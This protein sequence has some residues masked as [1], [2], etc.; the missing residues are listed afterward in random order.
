MA[1]NSLALYALYLRNEETQDFAEL[2]RLEGGIDLYTLL[3]DFCRQQKTLGRQTDPALR[4]SVKL[5]DFTSDPN[6]RTIHGWFEKGD[7]GTRGS[8]YNIDTDARTYTKGPDETLPE[9]FYFSITLP[10]GETRAFLAFQRIGNRS[11]QSAFVGELKKSLRVLNGLYELTV[12]NVLTQSFIRELL[13]AG[14]ISEIRMIGRQIPS[15]VTRLYA[16]GYRD[17]GGTVELAI[18]ADRG[19]RL[20]LNEQIMQAFRRRGMNVSEIFVFEDMNFEYEELKV[21][22]TGAGKDWTIDLSDFN[23]IRPYYLMNENIQRDD[24]GHPSIEAVHAFA[25]DLVNEY[26]QEAAAEIEAE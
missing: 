22:V 3:E 17:I 4:R 25:M 16:Y 26:R 15:D 9:P 18:K 11:I 6:A 23:K 19:S 24:D 20:P 8:I 21:Q 13:S 14:V 10:V 2:D 1:R 7:Y 12:G 5:I